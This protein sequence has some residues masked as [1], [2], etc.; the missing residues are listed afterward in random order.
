ME[1]SEIRVKLVDNPSDRLK[2]FCTLT[3]D[4][5]FVIRDLKII[6]GTGGFFVAMPSRKLTDH[7]HSCRAKNH[8]RA[9]FCNECG[10]RLEDNRDRKAARTKLH[11]DIAHPVNTQSREMIQQRI[12]DAYLE[13]VERSKQPGYQPTRLDEEAETLA[14]DHNSN[15]RPHHPSQSGTPRIHSGNSHPQ[16][17]PASASPQAHPVDPLPQPAPDQQNA[18]IFSAL[19]QPQPAPAPATQKPAEPNPGF[20]EGIF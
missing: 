3:F 14:A 5:A 16:P 8:L 1:I 19:P 12:I 9:K 15:H 20:S 17:A 4:G 10:A 18:Q 7:C 6:E 13:E 11:A 2:A